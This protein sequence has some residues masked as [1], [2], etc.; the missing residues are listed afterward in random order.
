MEC[1][2]PREC[3][4]GLELGLAQGL[5]LQLQFDLMHLQFME[6]TPGC[7]FV[8]RR[9]PLL[10]HLLFSSIAKLGASL[11]GVSAWHGDSCSWVII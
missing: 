2:Q 4:L 8:K 5:V 11:V 7:G 10:L 6:G 9:C 3:F 1:R